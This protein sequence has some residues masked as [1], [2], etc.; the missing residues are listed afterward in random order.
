[1]VIR[2]ARLDEG[3][4][5]REIVVAAKGF[6]GYD[7]ALVRSWAASLDLSPGRLATAHAFVA[8]ADGRAVGWAE[9]LPPQDGVCVLEHLWV[10]PGSMRR[11]VGSRLFRHAAGRARELGAASMEWEAEPAR[12]RL[13]RPD[14]R[15]AGGHGDVRVGPGAPGHGRLTRSVIQPTSP[16]RDDAAD[17]ALRGGPRDAEV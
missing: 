6:W 3:D 9:V 10:E 16:M 11:G 12:A 4:A 7:E 15:R 14:G 8:E 17:A 5:L 2:A 1:M 13:L